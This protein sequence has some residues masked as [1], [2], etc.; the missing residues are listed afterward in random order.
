MER[1]KF[2][3]LEGLE[4]VGK[5]TNREVIESLLEAR[6]IKFIATREPGGTQLGEELRKLVL[7]EHD[8]M[9]ARTELLLMAASRIEHVAQVIEPALAVGQWVLC[10]RF[11]DASV[12]YQGAGRNLGTDT[13]LQ[14][15]K[16]VG[17]DLKPDLTLLLDMDVKDCLARMVA[18]GKPDR[19]E[20]EAHEFFERVRS[21]YLERAQQDPHRVVV[22]DA[23]QPLDLVRRDV[24]SAVDALI[25]PI[26][27][28]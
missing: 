6:A 28:N 5:T 8:Q 7:H 21:A 24:Q 23:A 16:V 4:G 1:G 19:I 3:T 18:R 9:A 15:H 11:L 20:R 25:A 12:A 26:V 14:L 22:I 27:C 10:D 17:M 2:I 13:V